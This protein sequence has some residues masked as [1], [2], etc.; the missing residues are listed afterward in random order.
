MC[1]PRA[2]PVR[3]A[4]SS[5]I[6]EGS[7]LA[8]ERA[9][10]SRTPHAAANTGARSRPHAQWRRRATP[11]RARMGMARRLCVRQGGGGRARTLQCTLRPAI[12]LARR[13]RIRRKKHK[14]IALMQVRA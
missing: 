12:L 13:A 10:E 2:A 6:L 8:G 5:D 4:G 11:R 9:P 7:R 3:I 14:G 1:R